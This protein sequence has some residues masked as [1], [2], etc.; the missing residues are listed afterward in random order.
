MSL[1]GVFRSRL[2]NGRPLTRHFGMGWSD[3]SIQVNG[4]LL[5]VRS[6]DH[7]GPLLL[8]WPL[9]S[10]TVAHNAY[11][12]IS[13]CLV[14]GL[15]VKLIAEDNVEL[16]IVYGSDVEMEIW[17]QTLS[18]TSP[19]DTTPEVLQSMAFLRN[20]VKERVDSTTCALSRYIWPDSPVASIN[21]EDNAHRS[22][23]VAIP[24]LRVLILVVG[25]RGDLDPFCEIGV[26]LKSD[27]HRVR[28]A[29]HA[30]YRDI[31][32]SHGLEFFPLAGDPHELSEFMVRAGNFIN[33]SGPLL[34]NLTSFQVSLLLYRTCCLVHF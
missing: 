27:G 21:F 29:T 6:K 11:S 10:L 34:T 24:S 26:A 22:N 5:E 32:E 7:G 17:I 14:V 28:L 16:T 23:T 20:M 12:S 13:S 1:R 31:V 19:T 4:G 33:P 2:Q 8:E 30:I 15:K 18:W 9:C 25:T 3:R